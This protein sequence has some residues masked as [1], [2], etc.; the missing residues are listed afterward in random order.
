MG[1]SIRERRREEKTQKKTVYFTPL[2]RAE[3][4]AWAETNQINFSAAVE[5]LA[6]LGLEK[7]ASS[8]I[9]PA[10]RAT[11]LQGIQL[12]FNRIARL[13]S[14]IAVDS[15]VA[16]ILNEAVMLQMI[17]EL[18]ETHP[19]DFETIMRV[20]RN[21][22]HRQDVRVRQ[23]HDDLKQQAGQQAARHLRQAVSQL[24]DLLND[25]QPNSK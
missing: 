20:P 10:V 22:R 11:T 19:D 13:L 18:A 15:A 9:I 7:E 17:R 12:A 2:G 16:R 25:A 23:F 5:T 21:S 8:Y 24:D 1:D 6:L 14:D 4:E 3:I